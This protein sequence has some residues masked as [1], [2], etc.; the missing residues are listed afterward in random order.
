MW[1]EF[2]SFSE[3]SSSEFNTSAIIGYAISYREALVPSQDWTRIAILK[4][5]SSLDLVDLKQFTT[6]TIRVM[7]FTLTGYGIPSSYIDAR[8]LEGGMPFSSCCRIEP[9]IVRP[10]SGEMMTELIQSFLQSAIYTQNAIELLHR[11]L[12]I[13]ILQYLI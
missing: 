11:K 2:T 3:N 8:T 10:L 5:S 7:A 6:Y 1:T 9:E 4:G 13:M 12:G